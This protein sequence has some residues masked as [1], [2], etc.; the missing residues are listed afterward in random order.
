MF[1]GS[2]LATAGARRIKQ[3]IIIYDNEFGFGY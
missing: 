2:I 1:E 3:K